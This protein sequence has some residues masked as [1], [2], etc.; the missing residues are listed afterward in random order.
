MSKFQRI[1]F[2]VGAFGAILTAAFHMI[3]HL[4]GTP[5]A[6]NETEKT[7]WSLL[8]TYAF[9]FMGTKRTVWELYTGFS[10]SFSV[11]LAFVGAL[12]LAILRLRRD[13]EPLMRTVAAI[14]A[15]MFGVL[16]AVSVVHF[17]PPPTICLA[18]CAIAF[19]AS[20][21]GRR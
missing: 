5:P 7:L 6:A 8:T 13:D 20:L 15:G 12:D 21:V 10:L 16:L 19:A 1:A 17:I 11:F 4:Q 9:D 2:R 3:G 14:N 18:V